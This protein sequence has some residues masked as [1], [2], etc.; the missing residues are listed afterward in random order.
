[1]YEPVKFDYDLLQRMVEDRLHC[2]HRGE[3]R[4]RR[5][6]R[7]R[8]RLFIQCVSC[9]KRMSRQ[10]ASG[11]V[12]PDRVLAAPPFDLDREAFFR[13]VRRQVIDEYGQ[14]VRQ[15]RYAAYH[16][17]LESDAWEEI[18]R[19]VG[20]RNGG[21]CEACGERPIQDVHHLNYDHLGDERDEDLRGL[22]RPCH[23]LAHD[24][25]R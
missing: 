21:R 16:R 15:A 12:H 14:A 23:E 24:L 7:G 18:R 2:C 3:M 4:N 9:G 19:R 22:C 20:C 11:E 1:M 6:S 25:T 17:W 8:T 10:L 13:S 5:D